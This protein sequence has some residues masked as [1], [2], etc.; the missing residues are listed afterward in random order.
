ML[1]GL[2]LDEGV[3]V[4]ERERR[5]ICPRF[6][7]ADVLVPAD[8]ALALERRRRELARGAFEHRFTTRNHA[9]LGEDDKHFQK[10]AAW[11]VLAV[12]VDLS[13]A[14]TQ[15][16]WYPTYQY[17]RDEQPVYRMPGTNDFVISR[18]DDIMHV[19]RHQK[20]FPTGASKRRSPAAQQVYDRGGWQRMTPLGTNPPVHRDY[21]DLVDPLLG[22]DGLERWRPFI[23]QSIDLLFTEFEHD[24]HV[25][26][27]SQY[28]SRLPARVITRMLG[29][30]LA[31]LDQLRTWGSAW[32]LPFIRTLAPDEDVWVA[33][34]VV[35]FYDYLSAAIAEKRTSP[36]DDIIS[37]L[38][39]ASFAGERALTDQEIVTIVDHLF[40]GGNETT[41]FAMAS[42]L[43]ILLREPGLYDR[44]AGDRTRIPD[45]VEEV[46]RIE[47]PTQGLW[48]A[49][50][51]DTVI[52]G[53]AIPAGSTVHLRYA[54]GNRDER[55]FACPADVDLDRPNSRRHLA[56]SLGE[57]HCPGASLTRLEQALTFEAILD[58]LPNLRLAEGRND[59]SHVPMFTMRSLRELHVDFDPVSGSVVGE[60]AS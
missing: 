12:Y 50:A 39:H 33:E 16:D 25:E 59:F 40:I 28:S 58:R 3:V 8:A 38:T 17:L 51:D 60:G 26:W 19:L 9:D 7:Q 6:G 42:G 23:A 45:F 35:E 15:E 21:R 13:S 52:D 18:Y 54:S 10:L 4:V 46:L 36:G 32:V 29:L 56:F 24:G 37:S 57:H 30:P 2:V 53:V 31:D 14:E 55:V 48:R 20:A 5:L 1:A 44:L 43:W 34:Q 49:V 11:Y 27:I 41:T 47:S 22:G